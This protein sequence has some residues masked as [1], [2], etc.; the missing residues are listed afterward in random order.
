VGREL[1]QSRV[2][3]DS[4]P[5]GDLEAG[6]NMRNPGPVG[7]MGT[8]VIDQSTSTMYFVVRTRESNVYI[9]GCTRSISGAAPR[10][11]VVLSKIQASV[12]GNASDSVNG[13]VPFDN[14]AAEPASGRWHW[15]MVSSTSCG[16]RWRTAGPYHGWIMA[17]D[18]STLNQIAV[19]C[20]TPNGSAAGFWMSGQ[21]AAID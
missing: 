3:R 8:P 16:P 5:A 1:Q 6:G 21:G 17:Y 15:P 20:A 11:S 4:S 18:A 7:I 12:P 10:S 9:S 2:R 19:W 14:E 13:L